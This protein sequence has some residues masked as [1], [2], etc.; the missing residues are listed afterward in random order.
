MHLLEIKKL[1]RTPADPRL[2]RLIPPDFEHVSKYPLI[3]SVT[4]N[5]TPD[6]PVSVQ[7]GINWFNDFDNPIYDA[8]SRRW[9]IG[10]NKTNLGK[11][12]GGHSITIPHD[13][14]KHLVAWWKKYDQ[15]NFG[16][17]VGF[18]ASQLMSMMNRKFYDGFWMWDESKKVDGFADTNPG[19]NNGTTVRAAF[20]VLRDKGHV[21]IRGDKKSQP[22]LQEGIV[23]VNRWS[24][25]FQEILNALKNPLYDQLGAAPITN[26]WN[27]SYPHIVWMPGETHQLM[28]DQ[29]GE[30]GI[31]TDR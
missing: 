19:D 4:G 24:T 6:V 15:G 26:N 28:M 14:T 9:W 3:S 8:K 31:P 12:R 25:D 23:S 1:E 13:H 7:I 22:I 11:F 29:F 2:G 5:R 21:I 27:V 16:A 10:K 17:C 30:Y 18:A 20:D